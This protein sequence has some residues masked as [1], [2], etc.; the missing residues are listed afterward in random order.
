M[1][2]IFRLLYKYFKTVGVYNDYEKNNMT[3]YESFK[4]VT[5]KYPNDVMFQFGEK[6]WTYKEV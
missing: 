6:K 2:I 5:K 3:L 1:R 4:Q